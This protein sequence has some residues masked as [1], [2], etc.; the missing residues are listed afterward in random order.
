MYDEMP[1]QP[2][3]A[4]LET[5]HK[6]DIIRVAIYQREVTMRLGTA[7]WAYMNGDET[8][9]RAAWDK[10]LASNAELGRIIDEVGGE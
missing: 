9:A 8:A 6:G 1:K 5:A 10:Y 4:W 2:W 3:P 7:L